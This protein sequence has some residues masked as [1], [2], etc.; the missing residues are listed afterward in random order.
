MRRFVP[1]LLVACLGVIVA[2]GVFG[3]VRAVS[4]GC[5]PFSRAPCV[6]IL[7][8]GNSY[9]Y[10]NDLP[11]VFR[12]L[13]RSAGQN[14]ETGMVADGGETLAQHA[15]SSV[16]AQ[17]LG[18]SRWQF[19]VLQEQSEVPSVESFR[20]S[21][22]YPAVRSLVT[23]IRA[24]GAT[25]VLLETWAHQAGWPDY[26]LGYTAM[27]AA[28]DQGYGAIAGELKVSVAPAGQ[29]WQAVVEQAPG[30]GLWQPDGSHPTPAGTFLAACA[31]YTR[32]FGPC[33]AG[34]PYTDGLP[35]AVTAT[36]EAIANAY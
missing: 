35:P 32:I 7:F 23:T 4:T 2:L 16:D 18:G 29:A 11:A 26:S 13:A 28:I 3:A 36:L 25:P 34:G 12:D 30:I 9:T 1:H 5:S 6:R 21:Q 24:G 15:A 33:P 14:V 31:L 20:Q 8:L 27:Q 17:T 10:V 22:M 19:V